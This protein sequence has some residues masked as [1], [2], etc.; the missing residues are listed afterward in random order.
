MEIMT[1]NHGL[2]FRGTIR[3]LREYLA[4]W[5]ERETDI[6]LRDLIRLNLH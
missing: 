2:F 4:V 6:S 3:E 5:L 1:T